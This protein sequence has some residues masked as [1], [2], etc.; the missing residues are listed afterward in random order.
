MV[1]I[2]ILRVSTASSACVVCRVVAP[3]MF[4]MS[5]TLKVA[6][7]LSV[8]VDAVHHDHHRG[9]AQMAMHPELLRREHHQ[10]RLARSLK[11]PDQAFFGRAMDNAVHNQIGGFILLIPTDYLNTPMFFV[12]GK[13]REILQDVQHDLG[14][15]HGA[16]R[17]LHV[18]TSVPSDL[19]S[20]SCQG[21]QISMSI[22]TEP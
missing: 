10:Q 14:P 15:Q 20:G 21:P 6:V 16:D 1:V 19:S 12:R 4:G 17:T 18:T 7:I 22:R 13:Q 11:M 5:A 2:M 3:I 8:Q 9:I